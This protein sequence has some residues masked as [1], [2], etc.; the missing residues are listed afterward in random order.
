MATIKKAQS[1][2]NVKAPD[3]QGPWIDKQKAVLNQSSTRTM[4]CGGKVGKK[5][6]KACWGLKMRKGK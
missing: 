2:T 1:G 3:L 5:K 4:K 6:K